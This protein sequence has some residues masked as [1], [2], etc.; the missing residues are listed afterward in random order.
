MTPDPIT[1]SPDAEL[2]RAMAMMDGRDLR[3]LPVVEDGIVVGVVSDRDL[4]EATG[5]LYSDRRR[6]RFEPSDEGRVR[7][8]RDVMRSPARTVDAS[9]TVFDVAVRFVVDRIGCLP[10]LSDDNLVGIVTETD[11]LRAYEHACESDLVSAERDVPVSEPMTGH[12]VTVSWHTPLAAA[13]ETSRK[14]QVRHFPVLEGDTVVGM[15]SDRD[16]RKARGRNRVDDTMMEEIMTKGAVTI[17]PE[18]SL[19]E[20]A[21]LMAAR[22]IGALP[23]VE[24]ED[25]V[26]IV[27][28]KDLVYH[29]MA[30]LAEKERSA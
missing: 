11:L 13:E 17:S 22:S 20:A 6:H 27:S 3:H 26:G 29:C 2:D 14:T 10:V 18:Q 15:V 21:R 24:G 30:N 1:V 8:V 16:L 23:V 25:L 5:W 28:V 4:L 19:R 9:E 7:T 12:P